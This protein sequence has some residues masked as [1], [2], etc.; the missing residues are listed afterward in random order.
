[1]RAGRSRVEEERRTVE[2][3]VPSWPTVR[4]IKGTAVTLHWQGGLRSFI[5]C[6]PGFY[7][8]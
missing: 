5:R 3:A 4:A 2:T 6:K 1:M 7:F 8:L